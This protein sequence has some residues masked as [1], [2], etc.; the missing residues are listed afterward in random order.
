MILAKQRQEPDVLYGK[1]RDL[2]ATGLVKQYPDKQKTMMA[3]GDILYSSKG[4]STFLVGHV[5]MV[6]KDYHIYHSHPQGG[7]FDPLPAYLS[8]HKFGTE[9]IVLRP[10]KGAE[11]AAEWV[12]VA[13]SLVKRYVFHPKL[14]V[15]T[16]NYCS[17]FIWQ[18]FW[19]TGYGDLTGRNLHDTKLAWIY[20][21]NL[22]QSCLLT[23]I[24][25]LTL[26]SKQSS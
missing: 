8:R 18:A 11:A 20:P 14:D 12:L 22:K 25:T 15:I 2:N 6:G 24:T 21:L 17:K 23:P 16:Y 1:L 9:L 3:P 13:I 10:V 5:G 7:F 26:S 19:Y 4:L